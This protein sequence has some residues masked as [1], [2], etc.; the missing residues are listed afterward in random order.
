MIWQIFHYGLADD[1]SP[2]EVNISCPI[3]VTTPIGNQGLGDQLEHYFFGLHCAKL[4]RGTF[5]MQNPVFHTTT[6]KHIG[7]DSYEDYNF[8]SFFE[9]PHLDPE[10]LNQ[11]IP[12]VDLT[13]INIKYSDILTNVNQGIP[14]RCNSNYLVSLRSC[15]PN[16]DNTPH[17]SCHF[18]HSY[19]GN[20]DVYKL[21]Q[22]SNVRQKCFDAKLGLSNHPNLVQIIWHLRTGDI[23]LHCDPKFYQ[24]GILPLL[25]RISQALQGYVNFKVSFLTQD[26]TYAELIPILKQ[27]GHHVL[28]G[29]PLMD[30]ICTMLTSDILI[31][32][33]SSFPAT[34]AMFALP[35][36]PVV[37]EELRKEVEGNFTSGYFLP[38]ENT[39]HLVQG[40]PVMS[41]LE[42]RN[43]LLMS[44]SIRPKVKQQLPSVTIS[45][46]TPSGESV[47]VDYSILD[48]EDNPSLLAFPHLKVEIHIERE[49]C[50]SFTHVKFT[51]S[52]TIQDLVHS[53]YGPDEIIVFLEGAS[54]QAEI[55]TYEGCNKCKDSNESHVS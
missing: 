28:V 19:Y 35:W 12:K 23:C 5:V 29:T 24:S 30:S 20:Q 33:G 9:L 45:N 47:R 17:D 18:L 2:V 50:T 26:A 31:T 21:V 53:R 10:G 1:W 38:P 51:L 14:F 40:V 16:E 46:K 3:V 34:I 52:Q 43:T 7:G 42:F 39:I 37:L 36:Q 48:P 32:S 6:A 13:G 44:P 8:S 27:H 4:I 15:W 22:N 54:L 11:L 55:P 41:K 49:S 25:K